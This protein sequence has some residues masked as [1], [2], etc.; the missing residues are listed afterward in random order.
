[1]SIEGCIIRNVVF[2][3]PEDKVEAALALIQK[4]NIRAT[5][6][7]DTDG[8]Y[9]GMFSIHQII[10]SLL[11]RSATMDHSLDTLDFMPDFMPEL[12]KK[13]ID[14]QL[15]RISDVMDTTVQPMTGKL[16]HVEGILK[17]YRHGSPIPVVEKG[18]KKFIGILTEQAII[19]ELQK[20]GSI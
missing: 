11:P 16:P 9:V 4:H 2:V 13:F 14:I 19:E 15:L 20:L 1:M 10:K 17:L 7:V 6:V 8:Q 12:L 5:P 3:R 18:T